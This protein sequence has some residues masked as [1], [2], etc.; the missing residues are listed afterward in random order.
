M[1][2][3]ILHLQ[4]IASTLQ[5]EGNTI[6][7]LKNSSLDRYG[8]RRFE[9]G[10][11][12]LT[13]RLGQAT[14]EQLLTESKNWGG[15]GT[16]YEAPFAAPHKE[17]RQGRELSENIL[18]EFEE[19][20]RQLI[21]K[22]P[23]FVF[24]GKCALQQTTTSLKSNDGLDLM[25]SGGATAWY[26]I[27]QRRGSGNM[28]DGFFA[29]NS[30]GPNFDEQIEFQRPFLDVFDHVAEIQSGKMPVLF[31]NAT[32]PLKKLIES[33]SVQRYYED[34]CLYAGKLD[35]E[36]FSPKITLLDQ[37]Y[38]PAQGDHQFFDDE[39]TVR[40][41]DPLLLIEQ[42][43]FK[44]LICDL[45]FSKKYNYQTTGNGRRNYNTGVQVMPHHL[46]FAAGEKPW[47]QTLKNLDQCLIV[48]I[49]AGSESNDLGE[50]SSPVQVGYV[51]KKG[52]LVG[53]APQLSIKT[54]ITNCLSKNLIAISSDS[55]L[56]NSGE[57]CL[58]TEAEVLVS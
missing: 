5:I 57:P 58:I 55:F 17:H 46:R 25:S 29:E 35:Q 49:M 9:N 16:P 20:T 56:P 30:L 36:L 48:S 15:P 47:I 39:G 11:Q 34:S 51:F 1:R 8:V 3:D 43:R 2:Y 40:K 23:Q 33:F 10:K 24:S 22:Y 44:S 14:L 21:L 12:F 6:N 41:N 38:D 53:R 52:Q 32:E 45:R 7:A 4:E 19:K 18:Q 42:G 28:M 27:Y 13:S 26:L 54:S 37:C 31:I 50:F